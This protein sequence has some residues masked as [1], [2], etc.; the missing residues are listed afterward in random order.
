MYKELSEIAPTYM[1]QIDNK[2]YWK[3]TQTHWKNL[4][5]IFA[6]ENKV[7]ELIKT[8][9][10]RITQVHDKAQAEDLRTLAVMNN[11]NNLPCSAKTAASLSSS[12]SLVLAQHRQ[13]T[14]SRL[15]LTVT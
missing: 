3:T 6:K 8:T 10:E 1:F 14:L 15:A 11:G 5:E 2:D 4:G 9:D 7:A 12:K 13:K